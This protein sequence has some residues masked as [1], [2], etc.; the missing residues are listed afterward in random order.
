MTSRIVVTCGTPGAAGAVENRLWSRSIP[1]RRDC[2]RQQR[3][4]AQDA[5]DAAPRIDVQLD[6]APPRHPRLSCRSDGADVGVAN[7]VRRS[8]GERSSRARDQ[9]ARV[10]LRPSGLLGDEVEEVEPDVHRHLRVPASMIKSSLVSVFRA[11]AAENERV[12]LESLPN[13]P[14]SRLLDLGCGDGSFTERVA[15]ADR[16]R[17]GRG[18]RARARP[19][20]SRRGRADSTSGRP[21][22]VSRSPSRTPTSTSSTPTR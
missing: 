11:T 4:L 15:A 21:T 7:S 17:R 8:F 14:G 9:P 3:L 20:G 22:S 1:A 5:L 18:D 10:Q 6:H 19:R 12:I 13:S 2:P 16:R